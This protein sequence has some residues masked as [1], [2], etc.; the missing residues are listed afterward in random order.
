MYRLPAESTVPPGPKQLCICGRPIV[1]SKVSDFV[2]R[3]RRDQ[4]LITQAI[5][6]LQDAIK[7]ENTNKKAVDKDL[8]SATNILLQLLGRAPIEVGTDIPDG[9]M[10]GQWD[11]MR[12]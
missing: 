9:V 3:N 6:I 11:A 10:P 12:R 7:K 5:A 4:T 2:S 1:S 8:V